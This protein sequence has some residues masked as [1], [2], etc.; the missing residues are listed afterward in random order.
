MHS[1]IKTTVL[2]TLAIALGFSVLAQPKQHI[3]LSYSAYIGGTC[4]I[5]T[6][7]KAGINT[8]TE[9]MWYHTSNWVVSNNGGMKGAAKLGFNLGGKISMPFE[10]VGINIGHGETM[11]LAK[12][13]AVGRILSLTKFKFIGTLD[14][15]Y[16]GV[17][18][19]VE[20]D[21]FSAMISHHVEYLPYA[22]MPEN[23]RLEFSPTD[24]ELFYINVPIMVGAAAEYRYNRDI[25]LWAEAE[26]GIDITKLKNINDFKYEAQ[27]NNPTPEGNNNVQTF[28]STKGSIEFDFNATFAWQIGLGMTWQKK[29]SVGLHY[30]YLGRGYVKGTTSYEYDNPQEY[31][32]DDFFK[33]VK[34]KKISQEF[35]SQNRLLQNML[36]LRLGYNF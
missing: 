12:L 5:G 1:T 3:N 25:D 34:Y 35:K 27:W 18:S 22:N 32:L 8:N 31:Y 6:F 26:I 28:G 33:D 20:D 11:P 21:I 9:R 16:N 23:S 19:N 24:Y 13:G 30:Y 7:G 2:F 29:Y 4:P 15:F 10:E 17:R 14:V 36:V